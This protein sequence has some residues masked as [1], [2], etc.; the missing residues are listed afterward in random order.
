MNIE[1]IKI[2]AA[3]FSIVGS[4]I[5]AFRVTGILTALSFVVDAHEANIQQLMRL[6]T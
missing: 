4:G 2:L 1:V 6:P 3:I 5:L